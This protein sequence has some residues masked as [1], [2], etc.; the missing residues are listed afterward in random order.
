MIKRIF[1]FLKNLFGFTSYKNDESELNYDP[2]NLKI[3]DI[4][5]GWFI[6]YIG[7][8]WEVIQEIEFDW[9]NNVFSFEF[10]ITDG[11]IN[12]YIYMD[13]M[14]GLRIIVTERV[15][16]G[17]IDETLADSIVENQTAPNKITY[18][19][20]EFLL[21]NEKPCFVRDVETTNI[22][23]SLE[24]VCFDYMDKNE[25]NYLRIEQHSETSFDATVGII[26]T[27]ALFSN[28]IPSKE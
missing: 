11:T 3:T 27:E 25:Q 7:K 4:H 24:M 28:I 18:N 12:K 16:M 15:N 23:S 6:D 9:S 14:N 5:P 17:A 1:N 8:A 2:L 22:E 10:K 20:I 21:Q 13:D 19:G 26:E